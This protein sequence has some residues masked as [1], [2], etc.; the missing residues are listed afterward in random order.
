MYPLLY[1]APHN[2]DIWVNRNLAS[3]ILNV[4]TRWRWVVSFTPWPI[5][6]R[7]KNPRYPLL[8]RMGGPKNRPGR[9]GE[10]KSSPLRGIELLWITSN[11]CVIR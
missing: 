3:C 5:Y 11:I 9:G 10:E 8:R 6:I 7:G 4:G 1:G 2:E